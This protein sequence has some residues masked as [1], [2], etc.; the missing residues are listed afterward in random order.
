[1]TRSPAGLWLVESLPDGEADDLHNMGVR[2]DID[3]SLA[4]APG[5]DQAGKLEFAQVMTYRRDAL[6]RLVGQRAHVAVAA[7]EQP[8]DMQ[9][10]RR[11]Q[12]GEHGRGVLQ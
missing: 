7:G 9:A 2:D 8:E 1:M 3:V 10:N 4:L 12:Q 11:R 5:A 6:T